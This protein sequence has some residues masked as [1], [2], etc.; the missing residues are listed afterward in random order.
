MVPR[1]EKRTPSK[2]AS[3][4]SFTKRRT[5]L[6]LPVLL[7]HGFFFFFPKAILYL[8]VGFFFF[9]SGIDVGKSHECELVLN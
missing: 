4:K 2:L 6:A 7:S 9:F 5:S 8:C 1:H 3:F